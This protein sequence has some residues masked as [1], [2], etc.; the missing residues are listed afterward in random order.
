MVASAFAKGIYYN[1]PWERDWDFEFPLEALRGEAL[2]N[3]SNL[4]YS[5]KVYR[6]HNGG[7]FLIKRTKDKAM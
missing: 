1:K 4:R 6:K 3:F 2:S 5:K 7:Y